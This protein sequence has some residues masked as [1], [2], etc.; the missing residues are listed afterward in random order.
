MLEKLAT[1]R[2]LDYQLEF[3]FAGIQ[4]VAGVYEVYEV[5]SLIRDVVR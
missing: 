5:A 4:G 1:T 2:A 3:Y